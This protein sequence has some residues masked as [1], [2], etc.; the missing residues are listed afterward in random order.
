MQSFNGLGMEAQR[1]SVNA[2][3]EF[4]GLEIVAAYEEVET[5]RRLRLH[6]YLRQRVDGGDDAHLIGFRQ[7]IEKG[8]EAQHP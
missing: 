6:A 4:R 2:Y 7:A 1:R 3:A 8:D 5:A